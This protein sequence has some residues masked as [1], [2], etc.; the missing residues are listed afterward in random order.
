M[1]LRKYR[2]VSSVSGSSGSTTSTYTLTSGTSYGSSN[3]NTN[4]I[5]GQP[6]GGPASHAS[7]FTTLPSAAGASL[8]APIVDPLP[9]CLDANGTYLCTSYNPRCYI[10]QKLTPTP[11]SCITYEVTPIATPLVGQQSAGT[12]SAAANLTAPTTATASIGSTVQTV[13]TLEELLDYGK[14]TATVPLL[15]PVVGGGSPLEFSA[16][17]PSIGQVQHYAIGGDAA[18]TSAATTKTTATVENNNVISLAS[19]HSTTTTTGGAS[20]ASFSKR[21]NN[22]NSQFAAGKAETDFSNG[23]THGA[24]VIITSSN[25]ASNFP[26][27]SDTSLPGPGISVIETIGSRMSGACEEG[28]GNSNV[29]AS[30]TS[31]VAVQ[32]QHVASGSAG[33]YR[34]SSQSF[35]KMHNIVQPVSEMD[36]ESFA[37]PIG[38]PE[39]LGAELLYMERDEPSGPPRARS[40]SS[41]ELSVVC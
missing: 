37:V 4:A 31:T 6:F 38:V 30:N 15:A 23:H 19:S 24:C 32:Q 7:T 5:A 33:V 18:P 12:L 17:T 13:A 34:V 10:I 27:A 41:E 39:E 29:S 16:V 26:V 2:I 36:I 21:T 1:P 14:I 8:A 25:E 11:V 3:N 22:G 20:G 9:L 28:G 40:T 35:T